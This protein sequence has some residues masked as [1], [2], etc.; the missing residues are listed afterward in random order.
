MTTKALNA[1][2]SDDQSYLLYPMMIL[3]IAIIVLSLFGIAAMTG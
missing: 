2:F 3:A 1:K